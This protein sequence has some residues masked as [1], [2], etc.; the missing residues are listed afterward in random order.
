MQLKIKKSQRSSMMGKT[1]FQIEVRADMT[2]QERELIKKYGLSKEVLYTS[3]DAKKHTAMAVLGDTSTVRG[4]LG[5]IKSS[6]RSALSLTVTVAD[7]ENGKTI[8][9]KSLN[10]VI[11]AENDLLQAAK[12]LTAYLSTAT[13]FDG[14]E[15]VHEV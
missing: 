3:E 12:N 15:V 7:L 2:P 11:S 13:E 9:A 5:V 8:E 6:I 1:L 10:E 4:S 14:R